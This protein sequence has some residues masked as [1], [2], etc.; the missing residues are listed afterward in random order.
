MRYFHRAGAICLGVQE[1]NC[2]IYN[3]NGIHPKELEDYMIEHGTIKVGF[4]MDENDRFIL[5]WGL[6]LLAYST[7]TNC[8]ITSQFYVNE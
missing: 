2:A 1:Y 6:P 4:K 5:H 3:P 7:F 8:L